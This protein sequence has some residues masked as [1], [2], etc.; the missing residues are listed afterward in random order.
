MGT[1]IPGKPKPVI[2]YLGGLTEYR[3]RSEAALADGLREFAVRS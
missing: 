1:N 3:R 2:G